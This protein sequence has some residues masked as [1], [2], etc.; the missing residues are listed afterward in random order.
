MLFTSKIDIYG[1]I[2]VSALSLLLVMSCGFE[3]IAKIPEPDNILYGTVTLD[4]MP[5]SVGLIHIKVNDVTIAS[6]EIDPASEAGNNYVLKIPIDAIDPQTANT[7]RPND[8]A[9]IYFYTQ[10]AGTITI[11]ERGTITPHNLDVTS[12]DSDNDQMADWWE[13]L[14]FGSLDRTGTLDWDVDGLTDKNEYA[15][16]TNPKEND[17]DFDGCFDGNEILGGR[18]PLAID[19]QGDVNG[20][21]TIGLD[22]EII[23]HQIISGIDPSSD[24]F[25]EADVDDDGK[26]GNVEAIYVLQKI[27]DLR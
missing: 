23:I 18:D 25:D 8:E 4:G 3:A 24:I 20:D 14:H 13:A 15:A 27:L 26:I 6:Y 19:P 16:G 2:I 11:G 1:I 9:E 7:A 10:Y 17:T 5:N 21:C 22:D 12:E